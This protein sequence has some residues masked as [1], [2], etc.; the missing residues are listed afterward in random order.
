[1]NIESDRIKENFDKVAKRQ[2]KSEL[3]PLL[4]VLLD[5][6]SEHPNMTDDLRNER[7][8][9]KIDENLRRTSK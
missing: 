9:Q 6:M 5:F 7:I 3:Y 2:K 1:M 4:C 8:K